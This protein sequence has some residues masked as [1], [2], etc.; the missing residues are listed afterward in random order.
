MITYLIPGNVYPITEHHLGE[1]SFLGS[2]LKAGYNSHYVLTNKD[3]NIYD[4]RGEICD[5][6]VV[7]QSSQILP[8][9]IITLDVEL[10]LKEFDK[11]KRVIPGDSSKDDTIVDFRN[12]NI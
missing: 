1:K 4:N 3:G 2:A 6:I 9:F 11:W 7:G 12:E 5:E 8:S 10:C